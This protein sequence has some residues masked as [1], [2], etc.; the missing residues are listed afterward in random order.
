[1]LRGARDARRDST[2]GSPNPS[3]LADFEDAKVRL[4]HLHAQKYA[5]SGP[6]FFLGDAK[7]SVTTRTRTGIDSGFFP[8][9]PPRRKRAGCRCGQAVKR[10]DALT[11]STARGLCIGRSRR[12][13]STAGEPRRSIL[14]SWRLDLAVCPRQLPSLITRPCDLGNVMR[15]IRYDADHPEPN[16]S[17]A[18]SRRDQRSKSARR[19]IFQIDFIEQWDRRSARFARRWR[20]QGLL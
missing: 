7:S 4:D 2:N 8:P 17:A 20:A 6:K 19:N 16:R 11:V 15:W 14:K 9:L 5:I 10:G 3:T 1:V 12:P 13:R 18:W